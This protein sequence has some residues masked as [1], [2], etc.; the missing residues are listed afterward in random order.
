MS[1]ASSHRRGPVL[2]II[3]IVLL[4]L[5]VVAARCQSSGSCTANSQQI[6]NVDSLRALIRSEVQAEVDAEVER[7]LPAAVEAEVERRL[8]ST[9]GQGLIN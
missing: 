1:V 4:S 9:P 2:A 8:R 6:Q 3:T 5:M 7:R